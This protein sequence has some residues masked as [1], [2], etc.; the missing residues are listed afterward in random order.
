MIP[1]TEFVEILW[2]AYRKRGNDE[3]SGDFLFCFCGGGVRVYKRSS[4]GNSGGTD[5]G[6]LGAFA[7]RFLSEIPYRGKTLEQ[8]EAC[9]QA[10]L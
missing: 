10:S 8:S 5:D 9:L 7:S 4:F 1:V 2:I 3:S 6:S